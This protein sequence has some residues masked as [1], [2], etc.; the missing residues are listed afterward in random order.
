M[1]KLETNSCDDHTHL[2]FGHHKAIITT[3]A[4]LPHLLTHFTYTAAP[5]D[6][7]ES[8]EG[9]GG[10]CKSEAR[11]VRGLDTWMNL[12]LIGLEGGT[13]SMFIN[14]CIPNVRYNA[15]CVC[16]VYHIV[17]SCEARH[18]LYMI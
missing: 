7:S 18:T 13:L 12:L 4:L 2:T 3:L 8:V 14:K 15:L 5:S 6:Q 1:V 9:V 10:A 11:E 17:K 16:H